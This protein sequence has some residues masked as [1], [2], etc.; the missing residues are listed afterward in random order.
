MNFV[1]VLLLSLFILVKSS[2]ATQEDGTFHKNTKINVKSSNATQE[3]GTFHKNTKTNVKSS[4]A[5]QDGTF[6]KNTKTNVKSSDATQDGTFQRNTKINVESSGAA[7][8]N[9]VKA[10]AG[11]SVVFTNYNGKNKT[12]YKSQ[13]AGDRRSVIQAT[14]NRQ[15]YRQ[16]FVGNVPPTG[17]QS[18][19]NIRYICQMCGNP[20]TPCFSTMFNIN[21]GIPLYSAYV[22]RRGQALN[23]GAAPRTGLNFRQEPGLLGIPGNR[24][25]S[26]GMYKNVPKIHKGHLVPAETYSFS[27]GHI[28]STFT[29]TNAVP[30]YGSFNTGQWAAYEK[31]IRNYAKNECATKKNGDLYLLTG[32]SDIQINSQGNSIVP[33]GTPQRMSKQPN[34]VIPNSMWTAGCCISGAQV[35][36]SFA[37]IGNNVPNKLGIFM[38]KLTVNELEDIIGIMIDLFPG[39]SDCSD[40]HYNVNI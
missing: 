6:H 36:G 8:D 19:N 40:D 17:L 20:L 29:Y 26:P 5:T 4:N 28:R 34:I 1:A 39:N 25:G 2:Y 14:D 16:F 10:V 32:V 7:R 35:F 11:L 18:N 33:P 13:Q 37:V 21:Y 22:V 30:Q 38:S 9:E 23:F 12:A 24:Q 15:C 31:R 3:N 27:P